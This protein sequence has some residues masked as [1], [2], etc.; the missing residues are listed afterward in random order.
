MYQNKENENNGKETLFSSGGHI[1]GLKRLPFSHN[2]T[3]KGHFTS[4]SIVPVPFGSITKK[5]G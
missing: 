3:G 1:G 4:H 5:G 2:L